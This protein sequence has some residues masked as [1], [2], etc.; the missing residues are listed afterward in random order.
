MFW[1]N[2]PFKYVL[3]PEKTILER[4]SM[5]SQAIAPGMIP[6]WFFNDASSVAEKVQYLRTCKKGGI[7]A[8]AMHSRSGNLIPYASSEWY[9]AI[10]ALVAEAR[11]LDMKLWLYDE[12]PYPSGAAGGQVM[13]S[14]AD[15]MASQLVLHEPP[16][17][18]VKGQLWEI[19]EQMVVWAGLVPVQRP[20]AAHDLSAEVGSIRRD[21]FVT[22]WDSRYYYPA[23]PLF[24]CVRGD[25]IRQVY[26]LR[27]PT[28]PR[29][30][31]LV[32]IVRELCGVDGSWG[33]LPDGLHPDT[34]PTFCALS[35]D[36]Y[37]KWVGD[38]FGKTIPGIFTDEEKPHGFWPMTAGL[39]ESFR[40]TYGF[41]LRPSLYQ[42][43][44]EPLS[45][46]Y[47]ETRLALRGWIAKR[48]IDVFLKPYRQ[49][50]D[51]NKLTLVGHMSPEDDPVAEAGCLG[52]VM[53]L[54]KTL[55]CPGTDLIA[56]FVGNQHFPTVNLGS[57]RAGSIRA[58]TGA[59]AAIAETFGLFDWD[60][61]TTKCR[62][63]AAWHKVLGIDRFFPHGFF[64]SV[65]GALALEAPPDYGPKTPIFEGIA[66]LNRWAIKME[67]YLDGAT[68]THGVAILNS[69]SSYWDL[70]PGMD[71]SSHE[72]L[73]HAL[74]QSLLSCLRSHVGLH[75]TDEADVADA[76]VSPGWLGVGACRYH[77]LLVPAMT[78]I[79]RRT[80]EQ[81][82]KAARAG[83]KVVWFGNGP[84]HIMEAEGQLRSCPTLPGIIVKET[85]PSEA[86]CAA[87][88]T[89]S[90]LITGGDN[91]N[92]YVRRFRRKQGAS[93]WLFAVN[94]GAAELH[95]SLEG[96]GG[97]GWESVL[98]DG[99]LCHNGAMTAWTLPTCG[100]GLFKLTRK[101]ATP[102]SSKCKKVTQPR[103]PT[104]DERIF[105]RS[106]TNIL[107]L[108][109]PIIKCAGI[110]STKLDFPKPY[111]KLSENYRTEKVISQFVGDV[112]VVSTVPN[113][114]LSYCFTFEVDGSIPS[115]VLVCD[116]RCARG[117]FIIE[118]NGR[119]L[120][121]KRSFPLETT[122]ALRIPLK[123]LKRGKNSIE[124]RFTVS[125]A[126]DGLMAP[127]FLEGE[128]NV[129]LLKNKIRLLPPL[130]S[131]SRLG[132]QK[133]GLPHYMG[134]GVYTWKHRFAAD[135]ANTT[136]A[137]EFDGIVDSGDLFL[138]GR[139]MGRRAWAPWHWDL[140][141]IKAGEN[142][143]E[144]HVH[145]TG[146]NLRKYVCP[147]QT[148]GWIGRA[149]LSQTQGV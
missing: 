65:E 72:T 9:S 133:A 137:I 112:P 89:A 102:S 24:P 129:A 108:D 39:F 51:A 84:D 37:K 23:N 125:S 140:K 19:S 71:T 26:S 109:Q 104:G 30:Y 85:Y 82:A 63:V 52:S 148:Q 130:P 36:P 40:Q 86:W 53:P 101:L 6:F 80:F 90:I 29:G 45:S 50:C 141:D 11:R 145:G 57:L 16:P 88:L 3:L 27:I 114:E 96:E 117:T 15:L 49:W 132:W 42:L 18:L 44:G 32:A 139:K 94:V 68:D 58:Q 41:D 61:T 47:I 70:A 143:F 106:G 34:F 35:L 83:V 21:W 135:E 55:S 115:P 118:M 75:L 119:A 14:R 31:R 1:F 8:L 103:I 56:P 131:D 10:Q 105:Q 74:W 95:L 92:C 113:L 128:F 5:K 22:P 123:A 147:N 136:W 142:S 48:F 46:Q 126:M 138:N 13:A 97:V 98:V 144:L 116:P 7:R 38:E 81:I 134:C 59:A 127:L 33:S 60:I 79:P 2:N 66:E 12:D 93:E 149:W 124:L 4:R 17:G 62:Q 20:L 67:E 87:H 54:M 77:T 122:Q 69:L 28:I 99:H 107:R 111:W 120:G 91:E 78:R 110:K 64:S 121:E 100:N 43:F 76:K 25:A 73:R 146:G